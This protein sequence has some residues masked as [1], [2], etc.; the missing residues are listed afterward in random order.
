MRTIRSICLISSLITVVTS[1]T[2]TTITTS[3]CGA[4]LKLECKDGEMI[5]VH[6]AAFTPHRGS[7][8]EC[9]AGLAE[10]KSSSGERH[11]N[12]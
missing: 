9:E 10:N 6:E 4:V 5:V 12:R 1:S 11:N 7:S 8:E 3:S 2:S